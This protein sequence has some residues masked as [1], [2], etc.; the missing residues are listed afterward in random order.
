[1]SK[2]IE[3]VHRSLPRHGPVRFAEPEA[4]GQFAAWDVRPNFR[5]PRT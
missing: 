3:P 4:G 2:P 5:E 1:M